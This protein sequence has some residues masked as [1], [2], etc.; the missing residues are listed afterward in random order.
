MIK[1]PVCGKYEFAMQNN[2]DVCPFCEWE[3][4]G[5]QMT[6]PDY[7]GGANYISLN[8]YRKEWHTRNVSGEQ[9]ARSA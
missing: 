2:F 9:V 5:V 3:N 7:A 4:D 8:E 6:D 1:C